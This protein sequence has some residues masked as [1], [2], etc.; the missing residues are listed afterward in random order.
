MEIVD[1]LL[2]RP[3]LC[4]F[5]FRKPYLGTLLYVVI[6][7]FFVVVYHP[8]NLHEAQTYSF[9]FTMFAYCLIISIPVLGISVAINRAC[10]LTRNKQW[11]I[12]KELSSILLILVCIGCFA[13]FAGFI[14]E[15]PVYRWNLSTF[16][17]SFFRSV[18]I[19]AVPM[20]F[21]FFL[22][23]RSMSVSGAHS[24]YKNTSQHLSDEADVMLI[25]IKSKAK[26]EELSFFVNEFV[27]AESEGNYVV[28]HLSRSDKEEKVIIRNS[29]GEIEQQLSA[30]PYFMRVHRA[31]IVNLQKVC[32]KKGNSLG[33]QL[34][35]KESS[36]TIPVSRQNIL[37]F[38]RIFQELQRTVHP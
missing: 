28:F 34:Q 18:L 26:K 33:Y 23:I 5:L 8:L 19:G 1:A 30:V 3:C 10:N 31:F 24:E 6:L 35:L 29:I 25:Y 38:D 17:D 32:S 36:T 2:H 11:T 22:N 20:L 14:V 16:I 37:R 9:A 15:A 13:Y 4:N 21:S 27:Y 12:S 7:L